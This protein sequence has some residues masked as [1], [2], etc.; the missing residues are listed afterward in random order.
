MEEKELKTVLFEIYSA[1]FIDG[2]D[3][4]VDIKTGFEN[5]Y[6]NLKK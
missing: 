4:K 5:W 3:G 1:G 2:H 6:E